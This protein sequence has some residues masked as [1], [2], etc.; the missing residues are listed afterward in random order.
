[1]DEFIDIE[2]N[3]YEIKIQDYRGDSI[4]NFIKISIEE[5]YREAMDE[6]KYSLHYFG[7]FSV[8][9][10][11]LNSYDLKKRII[12]ANKKINLY[13]DVSFFIGYL[14]CSFSEDYRE[15]KTIDTYEIVDIEF[16]H[17]KYDKVNEKW[18]K[19]PPPPPKNFNI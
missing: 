13:F 6:L 7:D 18:V 14:E 17:M 1:M 8:T 4:D 19:N 11:S 15:T 5:F 12:L 9:F 2:I 3:D 10:E 16:D